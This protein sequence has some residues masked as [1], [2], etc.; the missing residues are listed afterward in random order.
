MCACLKSLSKCLCL[1]LVLLLSNQAS[2]FYTH[3]VSGLCMKGNNLQ[4][5]QIAPDKKFQVKMGKDQI[6]NTTEELSKVKSDCD[7]H[8]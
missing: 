4:I 5:V 7:I 1:W 3:K 8:V 6:R 2:G